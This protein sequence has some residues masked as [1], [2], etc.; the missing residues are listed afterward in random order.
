MIVALDV[1]GVLADVFPGWIRKYEKD[2]PDRVKYTVQEIYSPQ[3]NADPVFLSYL[4]APDLYKDVLPIPGALEGVQEIK[5]LGHRVIFATSC[6]MGMTDP[7]WT[8]LQE[9]ELLPPGRLQADDLVVTHDKSLVRAGILVD[10]HPK[11]LNGFTGERVLLRQPHNMKASGPFHIAND[12]PDVVSY[13]KR[14]G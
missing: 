14:V 4:S 5:N 2:H 8:W 9:Y 11:N 3:I 10:D 1:D 7:K 13:I 12:W 6:V